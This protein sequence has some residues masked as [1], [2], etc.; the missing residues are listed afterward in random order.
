M[1]IVLV[2]DHA[3]MRDFLRKVLVNELG[4]EVIGE[5]ASVRE[6]L[7][8]VDAI[9]FDLLILDLGLPD[10]D[11]FRIIEKIRSRSGTGPLILIITARCD[12]RTIYRVE[13]AGVS[14]FVDKCSL[15][16]DAL[17]DVLWRIVQ[18]QRSFSNTYDQIGRVRRRDPLASE[19][20]PGNWTGRIVKS[21]PEIRSRKCPRNDVS[22]TLSSKRKLL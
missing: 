9:S 5:A 1:K 19:V 10:G 15:R 4:Y 22:I 11:G 13:C 18:G 16:V 8:I 12:P 6:G 17:K 3:L 21:K 2:E 14:G 20:V 7:S